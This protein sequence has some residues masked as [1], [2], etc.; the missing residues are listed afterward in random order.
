[1]SKGSRDKLALTLREDQHGWDVE[2]QI[3]HQK[4][5]IYFAD[6]PDIVEEFD[7]F[8]QKRAVTTYHQIEAS[9]YNGLDEPASAHQWNAHTYQLLDQESISLAKLL[10]RMTKAIEEA[11][12]GAVQ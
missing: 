1:M 5:S 8:I 9:V 2:S 7:A 12:K 11:Y 4:L 6:H 3:L 10:S